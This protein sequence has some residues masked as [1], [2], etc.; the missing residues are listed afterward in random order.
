MLVN[1]WVSRINEVKQFLALGYTL[2]AI[3]DHYGVTRERIRQIVIQ[4][5][6]PYDPKEGSYIRQADKR[7][8][9]EQRQK[10]IQQKYNRQSYQQL[11]DLE[12][13]YSRSFTRK[14]QNVKYKHWEWDLDMSDLEWP[15]HCPI[16][17]IELDWFCEKTQEN[18]PS[19]DRIDNTK[20]YVKGN[21]AIISWRANRIKNNGT[22]QE[23][24]QIA[25]FLRKHGL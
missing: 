2:Q 21:V 13:A 1:K 6:L 9:K 23:H 17:G 14:K 22:S 20:G 11:S 5:Q 4:H 8:A 15:S 25:D 24:Q 18:S 3:G 10:E 7:Q 12:Q 19:F 16:L